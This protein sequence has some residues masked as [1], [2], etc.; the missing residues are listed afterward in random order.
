M[1]VLV[2]LNLTCKVIDFFI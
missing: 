2:E 1:I